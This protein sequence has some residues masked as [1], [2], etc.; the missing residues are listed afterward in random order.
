MKHCLDDSSPIHHDVDCTK[1][2]VAMGWI[3]DI[4]LKMSFSKGGGGGGIWGMEKIGGGGG[5][6]GSSGS[7]I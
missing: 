4:Q 5:G 7:G 1:R 2:L 3:Y 6:G